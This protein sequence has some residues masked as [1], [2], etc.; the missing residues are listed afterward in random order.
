[1][2]LMNCQMRYH[3]VKNNFRMKLYRIFSILL[4]VLFLIP[5]KAQDFPEKPNPPRLVNDFAGFLKSDEI[6]SL[7]RKLDD[8]ALKTST[9]IAVVVVP[10]LNGYDKADYAVQLAEKWGLG[11]KGK[12]NGILI[13]VKPKT[14]N[15]GGEI[16][17]ST[18]YGLEGV[19]PDAIA[20]RI[21]EVEVIPEF[22]KGQY[23]KGLDNATNTLISLTGGE[24][25]ADEYQK[26]H[27]GNDSSLVGFFLFLIMIVV[28]SLFSRAQRAKQYTMGRKTSFWTAFLLGSMISGSHRG[29][30]NSFSSGSGGFGG[31]GFGG[32][33]G[34]SFG[35]GGAGGSW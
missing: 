14:G 21:V 31:G 10:S 17:I 6:L 8:F 27:S 9:Q 15:Q 22:K 30:Y 7:E 16:F 25:T 5:V 19:V 26:S 1:M 11:Q 32:F 2:M 18:G 24:F 20:K 35:G 12:D 3:L 28:F 34:G 33:G 29:H 23:Y 13:L 4:L